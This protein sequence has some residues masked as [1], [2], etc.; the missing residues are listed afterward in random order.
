MQ[1]LN[2]AKYSSTH[3]LAGLK[4]KI[5]QNQKEKEIE[6]GGKIIVKII[7]LIKVYTV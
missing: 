4:D 1:H 5:D 7:Y 3:S 6:A 2:K